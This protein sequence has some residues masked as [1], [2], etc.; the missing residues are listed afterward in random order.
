MN[1]CPTELPCDSQQRC[2]RG[3]KTSCRAG[4]RQFFRAKLWI[5]TGSDELSVRPQQRETILMQNMKRKNDQPLGFFRVLFYLATNYAGVLGDDEFFVGLNH[6]NVDGGI[7]AGNYGSIG[8]I[9]RK[10]QLYSQES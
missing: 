6:T 1:Y 5:C 7:F 8:V 9:L 2:M 10:I 3:R 4:Y